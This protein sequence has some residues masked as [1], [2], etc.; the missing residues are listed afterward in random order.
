MRLAVV[1]AVL[2]GVAFVVHLACQLRERTDLDL[3]V[4]VINRKLGFARG[5]A[6]ETHSASHLLNVPAGRMSL[7]ADQPNDF[8][9]YLVQQGLPSDLVS[10]VP[11][12][13]FGNYLQQRFDEAVASLPIGVRPVHIADEVV[14][15]QPLPSGGLDLAL[16]NGARV[17]ANVLVLSTGNFFTHLTTSFI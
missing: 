3:E 8:L 16:S 4:I 6:Y 5:I 1:G 12:S 2:C 11:H 13:R 7:F 14:A 9:D 10:F 17:L 15:G